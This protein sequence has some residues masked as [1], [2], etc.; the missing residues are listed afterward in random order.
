MGRRCASAGIL[1]RSPDGHGEI[2]TKLVLVDAVAL[3]LD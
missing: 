1:D 2:Q 3:V